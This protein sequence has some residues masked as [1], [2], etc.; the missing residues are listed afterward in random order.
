VKT[1][2]SISDLILRIRI[3]NT[4]PCMKLKIPALRVVL[5]KWFQRIKAWE[6]IKFVE[7]SYKGSSMSEIQSVFTR[8]AVIQIP[9]AILGYVFGAAAEEI[10]FYP[11]C[12]IFQSLH[13]FLSVSCTIA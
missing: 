12:T 9:E 5:G 2:V 7:H 10:Q 11:H 1:R 6:W 3:W 13:H 8:E 4:Q